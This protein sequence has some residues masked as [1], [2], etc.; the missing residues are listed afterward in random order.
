MICS[1]LLL[2]SCAPVPALGVSLAL[3]RTKLAH[4][5]LCDSKAESN[6]QAIASCGR[7][8]LEVTLLSCSDFEGLLGMS[9]AAG[10]S[11][12]DADK[13]T[14]LQDYRREGS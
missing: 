6:K 8:R 3:L 10:I 11:D 1:A 12:H 5:E 13:P 4:F 9:F 2:Q 14:L 7:A